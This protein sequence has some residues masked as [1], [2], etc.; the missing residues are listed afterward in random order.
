MAM[1]QTGEYLQI[2]N[3][4]CLQIGVGEKVLVAFH[5]FGQTP[6]IFEQLEN[7]LPEYTIFSFDLL[8]FG[9]EPSK[10]EV[11]KL[12][13]KFFQNQQIEKFNLLAF[14][15]GA[16]IALCLLENFSEK[17]EKITLVAPDGFQKR[18]WYK[19]ATSVWGKP[20]F[21]QFI[22]YPQWIYPIAD[23]LSKISLI[24]KAKYRQI[25]NFTDTPPKRLL[26][27]KTWLSQKNFSPILKSIEEVLSQKKIKMQIFLAYQDEL[28]DEKPIIAFAEK[29]K[30]VELLATSYKHH[31]ILQEVLKD[32]RFAE[33]MNN[34]K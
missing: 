27:W 30:S 33:F 11:L 2:E 4:Q 9:R 6:Q 15:I 16:K 7:I 31:R 32:N 26:L 25:K 20:L 13:E 18:F 23:L 14:S 34:L 12:F 28:C 19:F 21:W 17:I 3:L 22:R 8:S 29:Q 10:S 24:S 5:G 1:P